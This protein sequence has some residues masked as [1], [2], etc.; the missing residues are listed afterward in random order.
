M[1]AWGFPSAV[2]NTLMRKKHFFFTL[3]LII[4]ASGVAL[5]RHTFSRPSKGKEAGVAKTAAVPEK[6]GLDIIKQRIKKKKYIE[7]EAL[8]NDFLKGKHSKED[9]YEARF[10]LG[11]VYLSLGQWKKAFVEFKLVASASPPHKRSPDATYM[12]AE[13]LDQKFADREKAVEYYEKYVEK[14]PQGRL[15]RRAMKKLGSN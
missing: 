2:K 13:L 10:A 11:Y 7:S 4:I 9:K 1:K 12:A 3:A 8:L 14:W 15:A 5:K 6:T